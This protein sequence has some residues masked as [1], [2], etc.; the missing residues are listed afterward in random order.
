MTAH[1]SSVVLRALPDKRLAVRAALARL[2]GVEIH[3]ECDDGR[4]VLVI[5]TPEERSA[6]D[7]YTGLHQIDGVLAVSLVYHYCDPGH[8]EELDA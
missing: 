5:E 4:F 1:I 8:R 6:L 2:P 3:A 7:A